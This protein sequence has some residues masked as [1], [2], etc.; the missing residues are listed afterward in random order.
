MKL[1][2]GVPDGVFFWLRR[3]RS[4]Q[5]AGPGVVQD[6]FDSDAQTM[7]QKQMT[8][9]HVE[10]P[11]DARLYEAPMAAAVTHEV[12]AKPVRYELAGSTPER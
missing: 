6:G 9:A 4:G 5:R 10:L 12:D 3:R 11:D 7:D 1:A 2:A 8:S